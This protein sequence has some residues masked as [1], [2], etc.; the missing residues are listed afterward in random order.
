[1]PVPGKRACPEITK[2]PIRVAAQMEI[3]PDLVM[4][5]QMSRNW[6]QPANLE[7]GPEG[8]QLRHDCHFW[9]W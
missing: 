4:P 8:M 6:V 3:L 2:L 5:K 7:S 9:Q 1:M